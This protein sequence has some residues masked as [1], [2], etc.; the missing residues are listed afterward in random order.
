MQE[1]NFNNQPNSFSEQPQPPETPQNQSV[2][3]SS[4]DKSKLATASFVL[5][6]LSLFFGPFTGVPGLIL[7]LKGQKSSK[8]GLAT[9]GIVFSIL[10]GFV[11]YIIVILAAII[12]V[13]FNSAQSR[14]RGARLHADMNQIRSVAELYRTEKGTYVGLEK[15]TRFSSIQSDIELN[16]GENFAINTSSKGYCS[17][18][19][20]PYGKWWC[21]DSTLIS[22]EYDSDPNCSADYFACD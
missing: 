20:L 3:E 11:M 5:G 18:V 2:S 13:S 21:V 9:A 1:N 19:K 7:G 12:L 6:L 4:E 10:F 14:A 17:E 16:G 22:S 8:R 15:D